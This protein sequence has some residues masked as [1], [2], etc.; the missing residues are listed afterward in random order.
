MT[1]RYRTLTIRTPEG[2]EFPLHIADPVNRFLA[3]AID[4]ACIMVLS[5]VLSV[6]LSA[7]GAIN[8]DL[9]AAVWTLA[10]FVLS[11]GYPIILEWFWRGQTV[12]KRVLKLQVMDEQGFRLR[13]SQVVI[14]NLLRFVD[15]LP[16][17]YLVGGLTTL[18][19]AHGQRLGDLAA[20]TIVLR[21][22]RITEPDLSQAAPGKFNSFRRHPVLA[23][24]LRQAV[25]PEV[26]Q[27]ALQA[28]LRRD[29]LD[30]T[31]RLQVFAEVRAAIEPL[32]PFP[33]AATDGLSDEQYVRNTVDILFRSG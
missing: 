15:M 10:S 26:A 30:D 28:L 27:V 25:S 16:A 33:P 23:A 13:F 8:R 5:T 21:H 12:G 6:G 18:L 1:A 24:R 4:R 7:L 9:A 17:F 11:L 14:R 3:L 31:A 20:G 22:P 32:A 19:N 2:I 29:E